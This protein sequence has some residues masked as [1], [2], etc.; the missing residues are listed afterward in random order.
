VKEGDGG[1]V[2]AKKEDDR[3]SEDEEEEDNLFGKP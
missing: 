3:G 1:M 2:E